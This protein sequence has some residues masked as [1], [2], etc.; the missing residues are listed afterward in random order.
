MR[1]LLAAGTALLTMSL[2]GPP[3][4]VA[5]QYDVLVF[6]RTTGFRHDSIP[7]GIQAIRDLGAANDFSVTATEDPAVFTPGNLA[8]YEAVVF[9]NTTGDILDGGQQA[10]FESYIGAGHG[11]VGVHSAADTEYDWPFYGN[12]VGAYFESHPAIQRATVRVED[13]THPATRHLGP[14]WVRTDEWYNFRTNVRSTA[15]VLETLD[16]ST[17][18]GGNMGADHPHAWCKTVGSGRSFYTG[19]GHTQ[20]S[21]A[22]PAFRAH[23]LGGIQYAAGVAAADCSPSTPT[24]PPPPPS[25]PGRIEAESFSSQ[26]GTQNVDDDGAHGGVR[27]GFIDNGDW[28]AYSSVP[29]SGQTRFT[30]RVASGGPGGTIEIRANSATGPVR[31]TVAVPNTGDYG[32]F[33]DVTTTLTAGAGTLVL[34]FAGNGGGLFDVDDFALTG[35]GQPP[36][37]LALRRPATADSS[38]AASEGPEKAVNGSVSGGNSDKWCSLGGTKTWR[39]DLGSSVQVG[40][41][42]VRHAAAGGESAAWNT[43]DFDLETSTDGT[44]WTAAAQVRGNTAAVTTHTVTPVAARFVR[45]TVLQP[46]SNGNGAARIYEVEVYA[47]GA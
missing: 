11:F 20:E 1:T 25:P 26:S 39:V 10:A 21:Y 22:D 3:A 33:T 31:G 30:A 42:V 14:T 47:P 41:I 6:S 17:Y 5:A 13:R 32:A 44:N 18:S 15:R 35:G 29:L 40:R 7:A 12:L 2:S 23:L 38:C 4:P 34:R 43:R 46:T 8:Q 24:P 19:S 28:L 36:T 9:L 16:E 37:N 45:L 27:V